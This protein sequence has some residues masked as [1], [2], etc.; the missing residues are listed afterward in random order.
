MNC[1]T[2]N[3]LLA[4]CLAGDM[5]DQPPPAVRAHLEACSGCR[6]DWQVNRRLSR[7]LHDTLPPAVPAGFSQRVLTNVYAADQR[8][9]RRSAA[10]WAIAATFVLGIGVGLGIQ[11]L[12][13]ENA[14]YLVNNGGIILRSD[15]DTTVRLAFN[16]GN[17]IRDV[18]FTV[19][20]PQGIEIEGHPG[21]R[22]VSWLGELKK[23]RNLLNLRV[24]AHAGARGI[25]VA[26]L[27]HGSSEK[28][29]RVPLQSAQHESLWHRLRRTLT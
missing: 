14:G 2:C 16:A 4:I 21:E 24:I 28:T 13:P 23:G 5:E 11:R 7:A 17:T 19:S 9:H 8:R 6:R 20:L 26:D 27:R 12:A 22:R 25:L 1:D 18:R 29:F 10:I 3:T 15:A